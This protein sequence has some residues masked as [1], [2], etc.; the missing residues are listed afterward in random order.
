MHRWPVGEEVRY[1]SEPT[2]RVLSLPY[3]DLVRKDAYGLLEQRIE[4]WDRCLTDE[5]YR[6]GILDCCAVD[7]LFF[8]N[9]FCSI[10]EPRGA[11][12]IPFNTWPHQ[13][14][15]LV[16]TAFY[17]GWDGGQQ[18]DMVLRKSRAQGASWG[19]AADYVRAFRFR[20]QCFQGIVSKD[21][22]TADS[23][24]PE[25]LGWKIDYLLQ[26]LPTWFFGQ[27]T[28]ERRRT[29]H[30]WIYRPHGNYIVA[31][32]ATGKGFRGGRLWRAFMDESAFFPV[33]QDAQ[34]WEN[35][36]AV[37]NCRIAASTPNGI[38]NKFFDLCHVPTTALRQVLHWQ[39]NPD[40]NRGLYTTEHGHLKVINGEEIPGYPY[41]LDSRDRSP[42]YD[43][44][45][46]RATNMIEIAR[47]LDIDFGGSKGRPFSDQSL[48]NARRYC[49]PPLRTGMFTFLDSDPTDVKEMHWTDGP[50]YPF[51]LWAGLDNEGLPDFGN[52]VV[53]CDV[54]AGTAG[55]H[56]SN[57]VLQIV[58]DSG[59][60]L[61]QW[62]ANDLRPELFAQMAVAVCYWVGRGK[63][64]PYLIWERN[65]PTGAPF[66]NEILRLRYPNVYYLKDHERR[67]VKR[68]NKPGYHNSKR[69]T[70]LAPLVA[71][72]SNSQITVH[73]EELVREC[74]EYVYGKNGDWEHPKSKS[75]IDES[76][77]GLNH[78]DRAMAM[79]MAVIALRDRNMLPEIERQKKANMP[80][81][82][83]PSNSVAGRF[84][85]YERRRED[86]KS[87][88][89][90]DW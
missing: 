73:C 68:T 39:D 10:V 88:V 86:Y 13:D 53:A 81:W 46:E 12:R 16:D 67:G 23:D 35:L 48:A 5:P 4:V 32:A 42:W 58:S 3:Y 69:S 45:C 55:D 21:E 47:E 76:S 77:S 19:V 11:G 41:V 78:G 6:N 37:T 71:A 56:S 90:C 51:Q 31:E 64:N 74:G 84:R 38:D 26:N 57:S 27:G 80:L 49:K 70:A 52:C 79:A 63:P 60:Q 89:S 75:T 30:A 29:D 34:F 85:D 43:G 24:N 36:R 17:S 33:P 65:G 62:A 14:G 7:P 2:E 50:A 44:E 8:F 28:I 15:W 72:L 54:A 18:R 1:T 83:A 61:G 87:L 82:Q 9:L 25:S 66:T 20:Q 40:Q 22:D 59:E